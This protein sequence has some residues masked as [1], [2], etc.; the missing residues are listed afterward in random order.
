MDDFTI[1]ISIADL[2]LIATLVRALIVVARWIIREIVVY[3]WNIW[4]D[5]QNYHK[6]E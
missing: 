2:V 4:D 3:I 1:T 5:I 6:R